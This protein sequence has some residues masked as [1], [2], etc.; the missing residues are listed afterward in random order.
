MNKKFL[1]FLAATLA[2]GALSAQVLI[3]NFN[4]PG[5]TGSASGTW[6]LAVSAT[7]GNDGI[8]V[9]SGAKD[10]NGWSAPT[11]SLNATGMN[12]I[13]VTASVNAGNAASS[14]AI[15]FEDSSLGTDVFS[16]AMSSFLSTPTTVYIPIVWTGADMTDLS[17]WS[18]GG[19]A[20][21]AADFRMTLYNLEFTATAVPE[22]STYAAVFGV[23]ALG[24]VAYRRR[25][26]AA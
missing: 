2:T 6:T 7:V 25:R 11:V 8:I 1:A 15:Q 10:E 23:M 26:L 22:P 3:D 4:T 17:S 12:F 19:G 13:A 24:F 20:G 16:V 18:L 14:F 21:G 5:K 9:G